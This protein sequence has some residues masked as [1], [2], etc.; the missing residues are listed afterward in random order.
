MVNIGGKGRAVVGQVAAPIGWN[1]PLD[2]TD[3]CG[4]SVESNRP[5]RPVPM[6]LLRGKRSSRAVGPQP[7]LG[8]ISPADGS[9]GQSRGISRRGLL[10]GSFRI[11]DRPAG[12]YRLVVNV[13]EKD[14]GRERGPFVRVMREFTIPPMPG[15]RSDEPHDLGMVRLEARSTLE[16]GDAA[17]P[18]QVKAV[19]GKA[20][21]LKEYRGKYL[22]LDFGVLWNDQSRLVA[23][24]WNDVRHKFRGELICPATWPPASWRRKRAMA[25]LVIAPC[26]I[27]SLRRTASRTTMSLPRS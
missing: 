3:R 12:D 5:V 23:A 8:R 16:P 4:A 21:S 20:L 24:R 27:R 1:K 19:D 25:L 15:G 13:N 7:S 9:A 18:F 2:F 17:P 26:Q 22:L 6:E 11:E 14:W 10:D